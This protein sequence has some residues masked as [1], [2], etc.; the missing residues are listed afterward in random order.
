M[1][2]RRLVSVNLRQPAVMAE[3]AGRQ[4][5]KRAVAPKVRGAP[6][7]ASI[8]LVGV[9]PVEE[10]CSVASNATW[11]YSSSVRFCAHSST[12][13]LWS[14]VPK[15]RRAFTSV[16]ASWILRGSRLEPVL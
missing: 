12:V 4:N 3:S 13:Q 2:A 11:K 16:N 6:R 5:L 15:P 14:V 7:K 10:P 8:M 9:G 1:D